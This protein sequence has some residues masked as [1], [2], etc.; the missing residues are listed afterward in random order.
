MLRAECPCCP[1]CG[2]PVGQQGLDWLTGLLDR[3]TWHHHAD[4]ALAGA[5]REPITLLIADLDRFKLINDE[6]GHLAGDNALRQVAGILRA[7]T[8]HTDLV[9]RYGGDEFLVLM[10]GTTA[11][12]AL[13]V[14]RSLN[15]QLNSARLRTVSARDGETTLTGLSVSVGVASLGSDARLEGLLL[16]AD[17]ALLAAKRNGRAQSCIGGDGQ[18]WTFDRVVHPFA[19]HTA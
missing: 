9:A 2:T 14:A 1:T 12:D 18:G 16:A 13:A 7:V 5:E 4:R 19:L 17:A 6:H 3:R 11:D 15:V 10:P 8:R